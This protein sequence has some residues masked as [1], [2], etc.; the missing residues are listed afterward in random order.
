[1]AVKFGMPS[2]GHTMESGTVLEWLK[3]EGD[4]LSKGDPL[5]MVET[6]KVTTEVEAPMDG[7][8]HKIAVPAGQERPIG[9]ILAVLLAPGENP[10]PAE[11]ARLLE[12]KGTK[13]A[14]KDA[15]GPSVRTAR[16][17]KPTT[18]TGRLRISPVARKLAKQHG[19]DPATVLGSGPGG[20]IT[21]DD[22]LRAAAEAES[23]PQA[24]RQTAPGLGVSRTIPLTGTRGRVAQRLSQSWRDIPRVTEV[25][26]V[27]MSRTVEYRESNLA[28]WESSYGLRVSLNDLVAKA[29][30]VA[31]QRHPLLNATLVDDQVRVH[32][33]INMGMAVHLDQ[34]LVVPVL[35]DAGS[36]NLDQL[37]RESR[38]LAARAREGT[39]DLAD[40]SDGTF[41]ITNLGGA[42]V[43]LFTPIINP[44]QVAILGIGRIQPRP[45]AVKGGLE[46]VPTCYLCLVF[47][48]RAVDGYPAGLF[49]KEV[50]DLFARPQEFAEA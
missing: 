24:P 43:D 29:V 45:L 41:T 9:A 50:R 42:H 38:S 25:M 49:L 2:L 23:P 39:L 36:M 47:D 28:S 16:R 32:D 33:R 11:M 7:V 1:M 15:P 48:H 13:A 40:V 12:P 17:S 21:K 30:N 44:P 8:L 20:R 34:G 35:K 22:I 19:V 14:P 37:A 10:D 5:L 27:D 18:R 6:D 31:L 3:Q 4:P 26:H 46:V